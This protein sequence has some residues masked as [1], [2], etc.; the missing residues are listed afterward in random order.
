MPKTATSAT[1]FTSLHLTTHILAHQ[2]SEKGR[3]DDQWP[4]TPLGV[5]AIMLLE[6]QQKW[7]ES[8]CMWMAPVYGLTYQTELETESELGSSIHLSLCLL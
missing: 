4:Q 2:S 7:E 8:H 1:F 3:S 5:P 6:R